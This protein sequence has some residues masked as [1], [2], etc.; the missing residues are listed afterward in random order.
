M[1]AS[2]WFR[3]TSWT[4][5]DQADFANRLKRARTA[6]GKAQYLRI[7]AHHL[8]EVGTRELNDAALGLLD[9]MLAEY[10]EPTEI[11]TAHMQRAE[12]LIDLG[13][14]DDALDAYR[15]SFE[16]RRRVPNWAND[17]HLGFG[18]LVVALKRDDLYD[19]ALA[20][21]NEFAL[22]LTF[23][24][25]R[26]RAATIRAL[27]ADERGD[28]STA[29]E[30]ARRALEAAAKVESPFARHRKLGLVRSV[31]PDVYER[32]KRLAT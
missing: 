8:H 21:L 4:A 5:D 29:R 14:P 25:D 27:I 18:G 10:P 9:R 15:Q 1:G 11:S 22:D 13:R 19:S 7:Q 12:C 31:E 28:A 17:A 3:R 16:V 24:V 6:S 26:Y 30:W 2:E 20:A 32:L 23:P